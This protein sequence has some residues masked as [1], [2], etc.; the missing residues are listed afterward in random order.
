MKKSLFIWLG[1]PLAIFSSCN[2]TPQEKPNI[3]FL[4]TD[5]QRWDAL[6]AMGNDVIQTPNLDELANEGV[7]FTNSYVTTSICCCS[8]SSILTG[9]YVSRHGINSFQQDITGEALQNTYPLL[10]K[11]QAGYKI[12]FIGKYGINGAI[13]G[14]LINFVISGCNK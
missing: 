7:L 11:N 9:Q 6:G 3:I 12:G 8:R 4:L 14:A 1:V 13:G 2:K 5:D 10:L